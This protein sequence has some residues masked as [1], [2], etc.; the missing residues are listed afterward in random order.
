MKT[1]FI[2]VFVQRFYRV[3]KEIQHKPMKWLGTKRS[4]AWTSV[5]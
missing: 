5:F 3:F 4:I 1:A 2:T